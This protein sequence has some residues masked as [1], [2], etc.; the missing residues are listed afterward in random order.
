MLC[1]IDGNQKGTI[2]C[3]HGNSSSSKVFNKF[4][5]SPKISNTKVSV[6]LVGHGENQK[7]DFKLKDMTFKSQKKYILSQVSKIKGDILLIGHSLGGHLAIEVAPEIKNLKGLIVMG[8]PPV[9]HPINFEEAFIPI[10]TYNS[11]FVET[12]SDREIAKM[13]ESIVKKKSHQELIYSDFKK[14][15]PLVR[16]ALAQ[17]ILSN[18][19]LDEYL[20]FKLLNVP[21]YIIS[22]RQDFSV[23]REYLQL[24]KEN[25]GHDCKIIDVENCGHFPFLD[26]PNKFIKI[27]ND[28]VKEVL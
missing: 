27:I 5:Q 24:V 21:K 28:I 4:L 15:N 8:T 26:K 11:Y 20:L 23:N 10:E 19:L 17:D 6:D 13:A 14:T 1:K 25:C 2:F 22:G 16:K 7:Q 12:Q 18:K 9:K 3:I